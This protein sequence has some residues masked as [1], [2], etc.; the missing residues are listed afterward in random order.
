MIK[1]NK[2]SISRLEMAVDA[3]QKSQE[4]YTQMDQLPQVYRLTV[5]A[6]LVQLALG[7]LIAAERAYGDG[8][9]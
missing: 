1:I 4:Y 2:A 3:I 8:L 7:D 5:A 6:V 9:K